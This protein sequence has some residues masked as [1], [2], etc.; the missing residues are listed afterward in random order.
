[1]YAPGEGGMYGGEMYHDVHQL[2]NHSQHIDP[3][4]QH[5]DPHSQHIDPRSQHIDPHAQHI[6]PLAQGHAQGMWSG[7]PDALLGG[8]AKMGMGMELDHLALGGEL[9]LGMDGMGYFDGAY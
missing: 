2:D 7:S 4:S 8:G 6:D 1:M 3:H 5:I 9:G